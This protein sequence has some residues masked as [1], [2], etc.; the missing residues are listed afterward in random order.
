MRDARHVQPYLLDSK[1][2]EL[3]FVIMQSAAKK[4]GARKQQSAAATKSLT[5][6]TQPGL[7]AP[8]HASSSSPLR[9]AF[10]PFAPQAPSSPLGGALVPVPPQASASVVLP[11]PSLQSSL[12]VHMPVE[13]R[14]IFHESQIYIHSP[15]AALNII[16]WLKILLLWTWAANTKPTT[17]EP[18]CAVFL[19][20]GVFYF[21][22]V[23]KWNGY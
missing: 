15:V 6:R 14:T 11:Q 21:L 4:I 23:E 7:A 9:G 2:M 3:N 10:V 16:T 8:P 17:G 5:T 13:T 22:F 19:Y 12:R 1:P 20:L 18:S